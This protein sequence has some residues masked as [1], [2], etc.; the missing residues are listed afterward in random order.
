VFF[1]VPKRHPGEAGVFRPDP[2]SG[3]EA[4]AESH[5]AKAGLKPSIMVG[6]VSMSRKNWKTTRYTP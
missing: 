6:S 4:K 5:A 1:N 3:Y 2:R